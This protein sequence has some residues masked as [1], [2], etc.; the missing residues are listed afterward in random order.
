MVTEARIG[1]G[2][3][4]QRLVGAVW[5]DIAEV[6]DMENPP[7]DRD[8]VEVTHMQSP[9]AMKEYIA[10]L[11]E[12]GEITVPMNFI[13]GNTSQQLLLDDFKNRT[14]ADYRI[15]LPT[16]EDDENK[17][18]WLFSGYPKSFGGGQIPVNDVMEIE[19]TF[20]LSGYPE[21]VWENAPNLTGLA[22]S[23]GTLIPAF[24]GA[25]Y[26]YF[27]EVSN[28]TSSITVTPTCVAADEI[29]VNGAVVASGDPSGAISLSVGLNT[30]TVEVIEADR[31]S[32]YY[33]IVVGRLA[34]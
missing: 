14:V 21:L 1:Y 12:P 28:A 34:P 22:I 8:D 31:A 18:K 23:V 24:D 32:V 7:M 26:E 19:V 27:A 29:K 25:T 17:A 3:K 33:S 4:V 6:K 15:L 20:K 10:G 13:P 9:N 2:T 30:I 16:A 11:G 5:T